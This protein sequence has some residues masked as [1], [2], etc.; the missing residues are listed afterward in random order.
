MCLS[1]RIINALRSRARKR[2]G[3]TRG[4]FDAIHIRSELYHHTL[5]DIHFYY[6]L[7]FCSSILGG[8]FQLQFPMTRMDASDILEEL[9]DIVAPGNTL[10]ITTDQRDLTFFSSF[11]KYTM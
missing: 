7:T 6:I 2:L 5:S 11:Q 4:D 1:A 9:K 3:N 8:D 10:F